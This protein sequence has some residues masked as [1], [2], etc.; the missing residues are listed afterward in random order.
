MIQYGLEIKKG[1]VKHLLKAQKKSNWF[2]TINLRCD[3]ARFS[4]L[5]SHGKVAQEK[6]TGPFGG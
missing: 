2:Q 5:T 6:T 3:M 4:G 1:R